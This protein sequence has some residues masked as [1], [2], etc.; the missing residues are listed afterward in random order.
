[1]LTVVINASVAVIHSYLNLKRA[2]VGVGGG[3]GGWALILNRPEFNSQIC[4]LPV[5]NLV[6]VA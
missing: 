6:Q 2:G 4:Q 3:W 5:S 1:M